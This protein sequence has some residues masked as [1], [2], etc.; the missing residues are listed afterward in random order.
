MIPST[1][2][3]GFA[4]PRRTQATRR[5]E[6]D[7]RMLRAAARLFAERGVSGTSLADVGVAAGYSRGLPV[8]RFG[9]KLGLIAAL[10]D[11][12]D[13]WFQTH[14][15]QVLDGARGMRAVKMRMEAHLASVERDATSTAALYSIYIESLFAMPELQPQVAIVTGRWCEGL[16][17]NLREARRAGEIGRRVDCLGEAR[18]L[19][20]AMRGL[21]IQYLLDR[22]EVDFARSK[23]ILLS[24]L[25]RL[26]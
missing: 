6:S 26:Q 4:R 20:A 15:A 7:R 22:S 12:M 25:E 18:F 11:A 13:A 5:K 24:H 2:E 1:E 16:A 23:T 21:V 17:G 3:T 8:E 19:L 9:N 10:L 14:I